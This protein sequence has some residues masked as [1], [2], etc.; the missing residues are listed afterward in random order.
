MSRE[1]L[2]VLPL[3]PA[4]ERR[5]V[6][7]DEIARADVDSPWCQGVPF[8]PLPGTDP[9]TS[10]R[11]PNNLRYSAIALASARKVASVSRKQVIRCCAQ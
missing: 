10:G 11:L 7:V 1:E 2:G 4:P 5:V 8:E 9:T 3:E 6:D